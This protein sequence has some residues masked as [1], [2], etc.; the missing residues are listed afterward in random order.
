MEN[1]IKHGYWQGLGHARCLASW[2]LQID[3]IEIGNDRNMPNIN[4]K[5]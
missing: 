5:N 2:D 4:T 1:S 3:K